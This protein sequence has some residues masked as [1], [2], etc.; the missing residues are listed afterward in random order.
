LKYK[1]QEYKPKKSTYE[2][3]NTKPK[4]KYTTIEYM[5]AMADVYYHIDHELPPRA[6]PA[7]G[8]RFKAEEILEM[9]EK[10]L[11]ELYPNREEVE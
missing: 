9:V 8:A 1:C 11:K 3:N 2:K 7:A 5:Q 6:H 10:K 4:R